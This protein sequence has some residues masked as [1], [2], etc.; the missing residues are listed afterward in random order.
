MVN[1]MDT[2]SLGISGVSTY[3]DEITERDTSRENS[4]PL[5]D[6]ESLNGLVIA[7]VSSY[8]GTSGQ[9]SEGKTEATWLVKEF[10]TKDVGVVKKAVEEV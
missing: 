10:S 3:A 4:E 9:G 5:H 2:P 7:D 8:L 6:S 1:V